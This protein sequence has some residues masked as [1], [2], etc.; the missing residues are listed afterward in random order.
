MASSESAQRES[1][2]PAEPTL[3]QAPPFHRPVQDPGRWR[4]FRTQR[5]DPRLSAEQRNMI[6]KLEAIGYV[7]GSQEPPARTGVTVHDSERAV[8]GLNFYTS[9]HAP[10]ARLIDMDGN[11]L[12]RWGHDFWS[13]WPDYPIEKDHAMTEFWRRAYL[14]ENGDVL[15]IHEGLGLIKLDRD[16]NVLW[17]K[18]N[19]AH[20]DLQVMPGGEIYMLAREARLVPWVHAEK[21]VLEDFVLVLN[22]KGEETHR[23]SVLTAFADSPFEDLIAE[24][25]GRAGDVFHTNTLVVLDGRA[26]DAHPSFAAGNVLTYVS[27]V[28]VIAVIDLHTGMVVW[29]RKGRP[30]RRHDPKILESGNLLIFE[31]HTRDGNSRVVE[32][33][34]ITSRESWEYTGP[35]A[36]P[37][38]SATCGTAERLSGGNTLVTES[39]AG[40]AFE[41]TR[42]GEIVWE[43][44]SPHRAGPDGEFIST[45]F[46]MVRLP[47]DFPTGW[48]QAPPLGRP[49]S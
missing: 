36:A 11:E 37:F 39:D 48:R 41:V 5:F 12:H 14:Y 35:E 1:E 19:R 18:P 30:Y 49:D 43:F 24:I 32:Y 29:A 9:G 16:S 45:L 40:R 4:K 17:A 2:A 28:G 22:A 15:G 3:E 31:N 13:I 26:A 47:P 44:Y 21:P 25:R 20:H 38:Y 7:S 42:D 23:V 8:R 27:G 6:E 33:E 34:S 46:E 10:E